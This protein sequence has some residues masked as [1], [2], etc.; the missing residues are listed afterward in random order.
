MFYEGLQLGEYTL[1]EKLGH[2]GFGEVW[3]AE[4]EDEYFAVKLP[5]KNQV[6]WKQIT[7]EIGLWTLCGKHRNVMPLVGARNFN[8][9]IAIISEYAPD[10]S[11]EDLLRE[12]GKLSELEAVEMTI[13]ILEGL[14]HLH[15]SGIIHRDLKPA[16]IL[17]DGKT[18]RLADFG[19]SR[20]IS[21]DSL[22]ETVSGTWAYMAPECFDG[23]RNVQTDIWAVGVIIYRMLFGE[24]PF[25]QKDMPS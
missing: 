11:L 22:S 2:G 16:N 6:N 14:Q 20:I 15:E 3:L 23:K 18:P 10:G 21:A 9:Q 17:L 1:V 4:K 8:G 24:L 12:K 19:I 13:G 5:H 25:P 7:Q